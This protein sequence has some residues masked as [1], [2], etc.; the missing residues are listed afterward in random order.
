MIC[1]IHQV[2]S[3]LSHAF[4]YLPCCFGL[5]LV[6][7]HYGCHLLQMGSKLVSTIS[8]I[9]TIISLR[10]TFLLFAEPDI[11]GFGI[12]LC[13]AQM[14]G[15]IG[16]T[17]AFLLTQS[18]H[19]CWYVFQSNIAF[20]DQIYLQFSPAWVLI[21][22]LCFWPHDK[23]ML[24]Q[25]RHDL[26]IRL[27][28]TPCIFKE[29]TYC[30]WIVVIYVFDKVQIITYGSLCEGVYYYIVISI[31]DLANFQLNLKM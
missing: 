12:I 28:L 5:Y 27:L 14:P 21:V 11:W 1:M 6:F 10:F 25:G 17:L 23:Y 8:F 18:V 20:H 30:F 4:P 22:V 19:I 2:V 26:G 31:V 15:Y 16:T 9:S 24:W 7:C 13:C 3:N 29:L